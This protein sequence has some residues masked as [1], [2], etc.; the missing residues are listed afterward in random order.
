MLNNLFQSLKHNKN[1]ILILFIICIFVYISLYVY[2]TYVKTIF[3][4]QFVENKEF[5]SNE[6][7]NDQLYVEIILFYTDWCPHSKKAMHVWKNFKEKMNNVTIHNYTLI[8]KEIDCEED[9]KTADEYNIT[10][11][12]TIKLIKNM[13]EIIEF[14]A[15]PTIETLEDFVN[16]ILS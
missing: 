1:M 13:D 8:F 11:Y 15:Q 7:S 9:S 16:T 6:E 10:G 5:V 4:K 12:P 14:D 3:S 2:N